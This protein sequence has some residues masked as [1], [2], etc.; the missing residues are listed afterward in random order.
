MRVPARDVV[1]LTQARTNLSELAD[2]AKAGAEYVTAGAMRSREPR[3]HH[4]VRGGCAAA[5]TAWFRARPLSLP[6]ACL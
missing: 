3:P 2:Q 5:V 1:P 4:A 6:S